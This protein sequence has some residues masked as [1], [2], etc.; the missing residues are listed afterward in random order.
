MR[1]VIG[2]AARRPQAKEA[3]KSSSK[4]QK[5]TARKHDRPPSNPRCCDYTTQAL[6]LRSQPLKGILFAF[7]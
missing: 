4:A 1:L 2:W 5:P 6:A 7:W 3:H